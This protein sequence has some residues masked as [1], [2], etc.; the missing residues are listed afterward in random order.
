MRLYIYIFICIFFSCKMARS[1]SKNN[2]AENDSFKERFF[3]SIVFIEEYVLEQ[4]EFRELG[5]LNDTL[6][7]DKNLENLKF[8]KFEKTISFLG[9][10]VPISHQV[11]SYSFS[12]PSLDVF[13]E[14]KTKWLD[15]YEKN[16]CGKIKYP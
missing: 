7:Y 9:R 14:D 16:K 1:V 3:E 11:F 10:Y 12:Y 5:L 8:K 4:D 2:C 6:D 13:K 15:W